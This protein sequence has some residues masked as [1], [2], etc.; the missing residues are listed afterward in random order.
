[1]N[2]T[3]VN[4][5][6]TFDSSNFEVANNMSLVT[7]ETDMPLKKYNLATGLSN[8]EAAALALNY[9]LFIKD[10]NL[11][12]ALIT[13]KHKDDNHVYLVLNY[14]GTPVGVAMI[15]KRM[16]HVYVDR[17]YRRQG[18]GS[19]IVQAVKSR[20]HVSI[21]APGIPGWDSFYKKNGVT[22]YQVT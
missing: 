11:H 3:N 2:T 9:Q 8:S 7:L 18:V 6:L 1:M 21:G 19:M 22:C 13:C 20:V 10:R 12:R 15:T 4:T 16:L 14:E 5:F 17:N